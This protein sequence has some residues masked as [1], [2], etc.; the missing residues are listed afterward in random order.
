MCVGPNEKSCSA[1]R[2]KTEKQ[3]S[4][5]QS[6]E[7]AL[8][9]WPQGGN[10]ELW[11]LC[12]CTVVEGE[13][14]LELLIRMKT[15]G[16]IWNCSPVLEVHKKGDPNLGKAS[17]MLLKPPSPFTCDLAVLKV[18]ERNRFIFFWYLIF[19]LVYLLPLLGQSELGFPHQNWVFQKERNKLILT[20]VYDW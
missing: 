12:Y 5:E 1:G 9:S 11:Q 14:A 15:W 16:E 6:I 20:E 2:D 4:S 8:F 13:W 18:P 17:P 7:W 3:E 10:A 19:I